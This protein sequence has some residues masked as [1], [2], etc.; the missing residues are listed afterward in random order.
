[1]HYFLIPLFFLAALQVQAQSLEEPATPSAPSAPSA[2]SAQS[3]QSAPDQIESNCVHFLG[4]RK[5]L[6]PFFGDQN[7]I[8][9]TCTCAE[10]QLAQ[11]KTLKST[12]SAF[13]PESNLQSQP[14]AFSALSSLILSCAANAI[15]D[16]K[17]QMATV[18]PGYMR[19]L[20]YA[21]V[22]SAQQPKYKSAKAVAPKNCLPSAYPDAAR[23]ASAEGKT[24]LEYA[25]NASGKQTGV[26]VVQSSGDTPYHKLLDY[27]AALSGTDC[28][29]V[30]AEE[31]GK[32]VAGRAKI[33][34][35]WKLQ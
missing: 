32:P 30:P 9:A 2:Q 7:L 34:V 6:A 29:F 27:T 12:I 4:A 10:N 13:T 16:E 35:V 33:E 8:K 14:T 15:R 21:M 26:Y 1:M 25:I 18:A 23:R 17:S 22:D 11:D 3:A 5:S 19:T 28:G 20:A 24:V 31:N